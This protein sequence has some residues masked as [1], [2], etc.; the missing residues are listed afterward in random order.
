MDNI[1]FV[2]LSLKSHFLWVSLYMNRNLM[3]HNERIEIYNGHSGS[4]R[5]GSSDPLVKVNS[6]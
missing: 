2:Q 4:Y 5:P 1:N 3:K 6:T